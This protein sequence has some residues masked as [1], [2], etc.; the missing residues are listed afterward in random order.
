[1]NRCL[2]IVFRLFGQDSDN[3]AH[4]CVSLRFGASGVERFVLNVFGP[5]YYFAALFF[6]LLRVRTLD[7]CSP[8]VTG[9]PS[10][11]PLRLTLSF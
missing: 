9:T 11:S 5:I 1:M 4:R 7:L 2:W 10:L 6:Q 8:S 3:R